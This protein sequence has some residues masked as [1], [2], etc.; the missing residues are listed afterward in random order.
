MQLWRS[1]QAPPRRPCPPRRA[2][3]R[4][5][6]SRADLTADPP[7]CDL[8]TPRMQQLFAR[9]G[10][11]HDLHRRRSRR[12]SSADDGR[13][14]RQ[15]RAQRAP[16]DRASLAGADRRAGES[17]RHAPGLDRAAYSSRRARGGHARARHRGEGRSRAVAPRR[18]TPTGVVFVDTA[19]TTATKPVLYTESTSG[20]I[21]RLTSDPVPDRHVDPRRRG[22]SPS[23][24]AP[25][26]RA[27]PYRP[28][29]RSSVA[30]VGVTTTY[31]DVSVSILLT[32]TSD[33]RVERRPDRLVADPTRRLARALGMRPRQES[34]SSRSSGGVTRKGCA[35][36]CT[37]A[38]GSGPDLR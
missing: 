10:A 32:L 2:R 17:D 18:G 4:R 22:A 13:H 30:R 15:G 26:A 19:R 12:R 20:T 38:C 23:I 37:R 8:A 27:F 33:D 34:G 3:S 7:V 6:S 35:R 16:R 28:P 14:R 9:L 29:S 1:W 25:P 24:T 5:R 31:G 11:G 36:S 21:W